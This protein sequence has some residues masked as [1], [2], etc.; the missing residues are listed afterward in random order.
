MNVV[1]IAERGSMR[2][3]PSYHHTITGEEAEERL[4]M[5]GRH[6][7]LTRFSLEQ[8]CY[9]LTVYHPEV[10]DA[11]NFK[12]IIDDYG[13]TLY[14]SNKYFYSI[15]NLLQFYECNS[16][17]PSFGKIG[18]YYTDEEWKGKQEQEQRKEG[19]LYRYQI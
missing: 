12:I 7:Y 17:H 3:H 16:P 6:S 15:D 18:D 9:I 5:C 4:R 19:S 1:S 11:R 14:G 2:Q 13:H 10:P 8:Q